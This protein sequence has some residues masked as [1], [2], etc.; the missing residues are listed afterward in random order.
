MAAIDQK[1]VIGRARYICDLC[2]HAI[3]AG[4][5]HRSEAVTPWDSEMHGGDPTWY[6]YRLH[7]TCWIAWL[8]SGLVPDETPDSDQW[9]TEEL[10]DTQ[11]AAIVAD[12]IGGE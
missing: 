10:N 4:R 5:P 12:E 9:W 1:Y 11:R 3:A 7:V 6:R 2:A 8:D